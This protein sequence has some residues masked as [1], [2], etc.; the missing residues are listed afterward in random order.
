MES[1]KKDLEDFLSRLNLLTEV[2]DRSIQQHPVAKINPEIKE[3]VSQIGDDL[4]R[5]TL[6]IRKKISNL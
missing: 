3:G 2:L 5:L 6:I 1:S 4:M